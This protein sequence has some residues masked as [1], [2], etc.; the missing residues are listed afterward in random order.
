MDQ[1]KETPDLMRVFLLVLDSAGIGNAPDAEEYGDKGSNTI[2]H[3]ASAVGGLDVPVLQSL[4]LGNI[5]SLIPG[6]L[7]LEGVPPHPH[8]KASYGAMREMS[9]GKDTTTGHWEL[10]GLFLA[11]GFR[12]FQPDYPSFPSELIN[13]LTS[14]T[15]RSILGNRA[16][17]GTQIIQELG[18]EQ[19]KTGA[20]IVYTSAD[21]VLQIAAHEDTIPLKE[22]YRA[23]EKARELCNSYM[24][25]RVI[26]RPYKGEPGNF[27]RTENRRD[28]SYPPPEDTI[29][30]R[31]SGAG[32]NVVTVGKLDDIFAHRG[33]TKSFH[34]ENNA[35]A[36][37]I[38]SH[39]ADTLKEDSFIFANFI[40]FDMLYGHRR[41]ARGY[42]D[43]L[44]KTDGFLRSFLPKLAEG[45][46]LILTADHGNDP[47]FR[48]TDH[49]REYAPLLLYRPCMKGS[50]L[51]I[52]RGFYDAA[53]TIASLFGIK[54]MP[55]GKAFL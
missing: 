52:R 3:T 30:D 10:A 11:E 42:A 34:V 26:A 43:A 28:Y 18:P 1:T 8:P 32:I 23:C 50:E 25:G 17:S 36:G 55:R 41:D 27:T 39:L 12:I 47:T 53:Q 13:A 51:G 9:R 5:P 48:G 33:M 6:G 2:A 37:E 45:D 35:D 31:L 21:S 14:T 54:A 24:I 38:M 4:G 44:E 40:D 7:P 19:M 22:L 29:L 15:G 16:A 49:T 46:V 20:W